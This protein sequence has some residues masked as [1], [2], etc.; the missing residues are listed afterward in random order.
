MF[1]LPVYSLPPYTRLV[2]APVA[3]SGWDWLNLQKPVV[4]LPEAMNSTVDRKQKFWLCQLN[5]KTSLEMD[6]GNPQLC[7]TKAAISM[8]GKWWTIQKLYGEIVE[9]RQSC[10]TWD[11]LLHTFL[12]SGKLHMH[13]GDPKEPG[14]K[15]QP[16]Y[17]WE[18]PE[19]LNAFPDP[20]GTIDS[21]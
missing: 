13:R 7:K 2:G 6:W 12:L 21:G 4:L 14:R 17:T 16:N 15:W 8:W 10:K 11:K 20:H 3:L 1:L 9:R 19:T 5:W 18:L